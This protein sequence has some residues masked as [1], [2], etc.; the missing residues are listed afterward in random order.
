MAC[1][2]NELNL[3]EKDPNAVLDYTVDWTAWLDSD[4]ISS[5]TWEVPTGITEDSSTNDTEK[6]IIFLS[7]GTAG[8]IYSV[9]NRISTAAGRTDDR[10]IR[11]KMV[12]K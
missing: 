2:V 8:A 11:I 4:T 9:T 7:G 5:S 1:C 6:A 12:N 10:T 3:F